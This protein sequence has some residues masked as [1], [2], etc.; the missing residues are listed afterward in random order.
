MEA[1]DSAGSRWLSMAAARGLLKLLLQNIFGLMPN[2][3]Q[4]GGKN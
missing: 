1:F 2:V 3:L 4:P